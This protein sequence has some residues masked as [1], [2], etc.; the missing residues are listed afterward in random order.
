[1]LILL[2]WEVTS[3]RLCPTVVMC[4]RTADSSANDDVSYRCEYVHVLVG[5]KIKQNQ[6]VKM[7]TLY[8]PTV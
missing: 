5:N 8:T 3:S 4:S 6:T 2:W 7:Y 1:M